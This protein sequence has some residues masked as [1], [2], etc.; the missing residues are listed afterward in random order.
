LKRGVSCHVLALNGKRVRSRVEYIHT[1]C[2]NTAVDDQDGENG[3]LYDDTWMRP[4]RVNR[5]V[6]SL[7]SFVVAH[8]LGLLVSSILEDALRSSPQ[9]QLLGIGKFINGAR[10]RFGL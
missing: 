2:C 8:S 9:R 10:F 7:L 3:F 1:D 4:G 5:K 6:A